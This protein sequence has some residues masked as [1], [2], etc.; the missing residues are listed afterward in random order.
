MNLC[1]IDTVR[2]VLATFVV[3]SEHAEEEVNNLESLI[4]YNLIKYKQI[5]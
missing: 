2:Q 4:W 5:N 1:K 3:K